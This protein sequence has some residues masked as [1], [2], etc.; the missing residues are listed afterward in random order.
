MYFICVFQVQLEIVLSQLKSE[1]EEKTRRLL[2]C[3]AQLQDVPLLEEDLRK[4]NEELIMTVKSVNEDKK[5]YEEQLRTVEQTKQLLKEREEALR[6]LKEE[7][8]QKEEDFVKT[9]ADLKALHLIMEGLQKRLQEAQTFSKSDAAVLSQ[10]HDL[11]EMSNKYKDQC[12]TFKDTIIS[13]EEKLE[14]AQKNLLEE[15]IAHN[16]LENVLDELG[17]SKQNI[18]SDLVATKSK[19]KSLQEELDSAM[20]HAEENRSK[21]ETLSL[22]LEASLKENKKL[23]ANCQRLKKEID[24]LSRKQKT[25]LQNVIKKDSEEAAKVKNQLIQLKSENSD[26]KLEYEKLKQDLEEVGSNI[27]LLKELQ[28]KDDKILKLEMELKQL[29]EN[30]DSLKYDKLK[31]EEGLNTEISELNNQINDLNKNIVSLETE[32]KDS[33]DSIRN[34]NLSRKYE[35]LKRE[36]DRQRRARRE[37]EKRY[38]G[39]KEELMKEKQFCA[40][41]QSEATEKRVPKLGV[42]KANIVDIR[43][44]GVRPASKYTVHCQVIII[45]K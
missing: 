7:L 16:S 5:F 10:L 13:L 43:S 30:N 21:I 32:S 26:L 25:E 2:E 35:I 31:T 18:V 3:E 44:E 11:K 38:S 17:T 37:V 12:E 27:D 6:N 19:C 23:S 42:T 15:K 24:Q 41:L 45:F 20:L 36:Y 28:N 39:L 14:V 8:A 1:L 29:E 40:Q 33:H 34:E 9:T 4:A 22:D